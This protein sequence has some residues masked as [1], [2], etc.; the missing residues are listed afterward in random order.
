MDKYNYEYKYKICKNK[1]NKYKNKYLYYKGRYEYYKDRYLNVSY[2]P[3][4]KIKHLNK[5]Y[6]D[7]LSCTNPTHNYTNIDNIKYCFDKGLKLACL[8]NDNIKEYTIKQHRLPYEKG[9]GSTEGYVIYKDNI[10]HKIFRQVVDYF[11]SFD[12]KLNTYFIN[13]LKDPSMIGDIING[14]FFGY[15]FINIAEFVLRHTD[16]LIQHRLIDLVNR[17]VCQD[18]SII[19]NYSKEQ[20]INELFKRSQSVKVNISL[21]QVFT[22]IHKVAKEILSK[23]KLYPNNFDM[24]SRVINNIIIATMFHGD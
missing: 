23:I 21:T 22:T 12:S 20:L 18:N 2:N 6:R 10:T 24:N 19:F 5:D 17:G 13:D 14:F 7:E 8:P 4:I 9:K 16:I 3:F 15:G 1:Y 11:R